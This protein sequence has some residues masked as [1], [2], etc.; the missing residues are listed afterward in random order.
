MKSYKSITLKYMSVEYKDF[1]QTNIPSE[2]NVKLL[3]R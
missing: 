2:N 1:D 3:I